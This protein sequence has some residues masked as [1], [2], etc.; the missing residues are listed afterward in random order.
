MMVFEPGAELDAMIAKEVMGLD[1]HFRKHGESK[2]HFDGYFVKAP[3]WP[4]V[5]KYSTDISAA[6]EVV[7]KLEHDVLLCRHFRVDTTPYRISVYHDGP[8][9]G[10][11]G[12]VKSTKTKSYQ[13]SEL[14]A[15]Y[16]ICLVALKSVKADLDAQ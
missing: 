12:N 8:K 16:A 3:G 2:K 6:W 5:K 9:S 10:Y 14:T 1:V 15:P 7:E 13:A 11:T 4:K